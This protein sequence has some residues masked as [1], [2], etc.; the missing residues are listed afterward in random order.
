MAEQAGPSKMQM[1][2][3]REAASQGD[4]LN[5]L[6]AT[7]SGLRDDIAGAREELKS[8]QELCRETFPRRKKDPSASEPA[9]LPFPRSPSL[10]N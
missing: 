3:R 7:L 6:E 10:K 5:Q 9:V 8:A 1:A 2:R 4:E